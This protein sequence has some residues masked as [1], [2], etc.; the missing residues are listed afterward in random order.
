MD[1]VW[2]TP[3]TAFVEGEG[4]SAMIQPT[5]SGELMSGTFGA[6]RNGGTRFH[7]GLDLKPVMKRT[8]KGEATD[9][10]YAAFSGQVVHVSSVAGRSSYGRYVVLLHNSDGVEFYT[11]YAHLASVE[12]ALR[13]GQQVD[14]GTVIGV[15]GRSA[16]GYSIPK[17]RAH[18][19]FEIG[20]VLGGS[21]QPWYD[22]QKYT[23]PNYHGN[24]NGMNLS[25]FDPLD[26]ANAY[27]EGRAASMAQYIRSL[28][29]AYVLR[30]N[31]EG[32]PAIVKHSPALLTAPI[33]EE[34]A[35]AWDISFTWYGL[36]TSFTPL[37]KADVGAM[38]KPGVIRIRAINR[39]IVA[40]NR[41]RNTV[42]IKNGKPSLYK[43]QSNWLEMMFGR[44]LGSS[45]K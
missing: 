16:A 12:G 40:S 3:N 22:R 1:F 8:R 14:A 30:V 2:P 43:D 24:Y 42:R 23:T 10:I 19:H 9:P 21:F 35:A 44:K 33:P 29:T 15:M 36:P 7:E 4:L 45:G 5:V 28:P 20:L 38:D 13:K 17:D 25:G 39:D 31:A 11:L 34:G 37:R 41:A 6:V 18:L 26:F 27:R 32:V